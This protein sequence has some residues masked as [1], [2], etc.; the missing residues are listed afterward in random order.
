MEIEGGRVGPPFSLIEASPREFKVRRIGPSR[1]F[2]PENVFV[3]F[4]SCLV[5]GISTQIDSRDRR[6]HGKEW[7]SLRQRGAQGATGAK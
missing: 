6:A 4:P 7:R 2:E 5:H 1:I 3:P